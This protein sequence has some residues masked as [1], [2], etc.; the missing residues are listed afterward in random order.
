M[1]HNL[2]P[3]QPKQTFLTSCQGNGLR[4]RS[5]VRAE[6]VKAERSASKCYSG[7][8]WKSFCWAR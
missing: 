8:A 2:S 7:D 4:L 5:A 3:T 1:P 6:V